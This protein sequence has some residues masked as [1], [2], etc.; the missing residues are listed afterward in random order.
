M[1]KMS[2]VSNML[3]ENLLWMSKR[4]ESFPMLAEKHRVLLF[5]ELRNQSCA[6]C[7]KL[8]LFHGLSLTHFL[9]RGALPIIFRW[10]QG[11]R[12]I[13][14][15]SPS[16]SLCFLFYL[17]MPKV[18]RKWPEA[19]AAPM[20]HTGHVNCE[21]DISHLLPVLTRPLRTLTSRATC[22][23]PIQFVSASMDFGK[24]FYL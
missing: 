22:L 4:E 13:R 18:R 17:V 15:I 1:L 16:L 6:F 14:S 8:L 24:L 23:F 21:T 9:W 2:D 7:C 20:G 3:S 10:M 12:M 5:L 19:T 11:C